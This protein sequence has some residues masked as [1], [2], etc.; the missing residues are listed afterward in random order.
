MGDTG[1]W[2]WQLDQRVERE[3]KV[4][5]SLPND[6]DIGRT[7]R[8]VDQGLT[9]Y[10][11]GEPLRLESADN[12][13]S[14]KGSIDSEPPSPIMTPEPPRCTTA[15]ALPRSMRAKEEY[16]YKECTDPFCFGCLRN[17]GRPNNSLCYTTNVTIHTITP[18]HILGYSQIGEVWI[19]K[20]YLSTMKRM[21]ASRTDLRSHK[22]RMVIM[23]NES[24]MIKTPQT[25]LRCIWIWK[26]PLLEDQ[27]VVH[28]PPAS[29][30]IMEG[31]FICAPISSTIV[32]C[33]NL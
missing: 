23:K 4:E 21:R 33:T 5:P 26:K 29:Y 28:H 6:L 31:A 11:D 8:L 22:F 32:N 7:R 9:P 2:G 17:G 12:S 18:T 16:H 30:P 20:K 3:S 27:V 19:H 1:E 25:P 13:P 15:K 14:F 10:Y 24:T